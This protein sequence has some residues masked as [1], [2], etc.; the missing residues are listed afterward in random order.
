MRGRE[1]TATDI[2]KLSRE[3]LIPILNARLDEMRAWLEANRIKADKPQAGWMFF[4]PV[5]KDAYPFF[6]IQDQGNGLWLCA[7]A[8]AIEISEA[9][10]FDLYL[11][12]VDWAG[13]YSI[14]VE[15]WN[16]ILLHEKDMGQNYSQGISAEWVARALELRQ[17][18]QTT[19][20]V[21]A[22]LLAF[23][24]PDEGLLA[25]WNER[26]AAAVEAVRQ[27]FHEGRR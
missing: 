9:G 4:V 15:C 14:L 11:L 1:G 6:V 26:E 13:G 23:T 22:G 25:D 7:K 18:Y 2:K 16:V 8:D 12:P 20:I 3:E 21:P 10:Q 19:G 24:G 17:A 27:K 5:G